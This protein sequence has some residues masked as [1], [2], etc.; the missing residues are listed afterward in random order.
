MLKDAPG[1]TRTCLNVKSPVMPLGFSEPRDILAHK[2]LP[3]ETACIT[4]FSLSGGLSLTHVHTT[5]ENR[6][7]VKDVASGNCLWFTKQCSE[8][9][10]SSIWLVTKLTSA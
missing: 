3:R 9:H 6:Q 7:P 10:E 1:P 4:N 5:G 2:A 8:E